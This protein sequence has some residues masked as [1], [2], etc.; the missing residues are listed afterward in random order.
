MRSPLQ[1]K[2]TSLSDGEWETA[3]REVIVLMLQFLIALIVSAVS[4]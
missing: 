2:G 4:P 3:G 1:S